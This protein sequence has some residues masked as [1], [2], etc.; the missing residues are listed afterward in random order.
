MIDAEAW[1]ARPLARTRFR[2]NESCEKTVSLQIS[3][4]LA[5]HSHLVY[6]ESHPLHGKWAVTERPQKKCA[7]TV[8]G[9]SR[10]SSSSSNFASDSQPLKFCLRLFRDEDNLIVVEFQRRQG[11]GPLFKKIFN[12]FC[13]G[14]T[15]CLSYPPLT[16]SSPSAVS[17]GFLSVKS[18]SQARTTE[19][20]SQF[21]PL[22]LPIAC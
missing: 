2:T 12:A 15:A 18:M 4:F 14:S 7:A 8:S 17:F 11:G 20:S 16:C 19:V 21:P 5:R 13:S 6:A 10:N 9:S 3:S 22:P 1:P